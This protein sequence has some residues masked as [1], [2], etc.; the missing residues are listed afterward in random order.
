MEYTMP[1][2]IKTKVIMPDKAVLA[3]D[4]WR[5]R[6]GTGTALI[7]PAVDESPDEEFIEESAADR[8]FTILEASRD[9]ERA[10]VKLF[11]MT[12]ANKYAWLEDYTPDEFETGGYRMI[13]DTFGNG[14]YEIRLYGIH[15]RLQQ[16]RVLAKPRITIEG[17]PDKPAADAAPAV[18]PELVAML[19]SQQE[20]QAAILAALNNRPD[21]MAQLSGLITMMGAMREA[22]GLNNPPAPTSEKSSIA[23]VVAAVKELRAVSSELN[24]EPAGDPSDPATLLPGIMDLVKTAMQSR[25]QDASQTQELPSVLMP[26]EYAD[27]STPSPAGDPV[28]LCVTP[29]DMKALGMN[30]IQ[31]LTLQGNLAKLAKMADDAADPVAGAAL[32]RDKLPAQ[33]APYLASPQWWPMLNA[34]APGVATEPRR[35]WFTAARDRALKV[36]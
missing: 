29:E 16:F 20:S 34:V 36:T 14:E 8:V 19:K 27:L 25:A 18:A 28:S 22:F 13:R 1:T 15:P 9:V 3:E 2:D 6:L 33:F 11:R 24:P 4:N 5:A 10:V 17:A 30:P 26:A 32:L 35:A 7:P 23:E 31:L 21:Q 12:G